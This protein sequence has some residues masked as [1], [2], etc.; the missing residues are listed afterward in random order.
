MRHQLIGGGAPHQRR[1]Q[2]CQNSVDRYQRQHDRQREVA[3]DR[4]YHSEHERLEH[5]DHGQQEARVQW[6]R[7]GR[8]H[9]RQN[10]RQE[11]HGEKE[12]RGSQGAAGAVVDEDGKRH[13][14]DRVAHLVDPTS[15]G[16]VTEG[17]R[18]QGLQIEHT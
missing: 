6:L 3:G 17:R 7:V 4:G 15:C 16:Q 11:S 2:D 5:V 13:L 10:C 14:T 12:G 8:H 9:R 18:A 1:R